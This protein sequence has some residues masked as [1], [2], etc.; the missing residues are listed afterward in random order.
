MKT[1][2]KDFGFDLPEINQQNFWEPG[3][4]IRMGNPP[5]RIEL[6]SQASGIEFDDCFQNRVKD[7]IDGIEVNIISISDLKKNKLAAGRHKDFD[8][9]ENLP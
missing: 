1:V 5:I 3:K 2:L 9:L 6:I 4:I 7:I 8:D